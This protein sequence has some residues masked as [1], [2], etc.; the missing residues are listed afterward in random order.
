MQELPSSRRLPASLRPLAE[1]QH[2]VVTRA[3]L[4]ALHLGHEAVRSRTAQGIWRALGPRVVVLHTGTLSRQQKEWVGVLHSGPG[5][6]LAR[7]TA[8]TAAGLRGFEEPDV[9]VAVEHGREVSDLVHPLVTV[10]IHQT[11]RPA[12]ELALAREPVRHSIARAV[13]EMASAAATDNRCR[14]VLAAVVQQRLVRPDHLRDVIRTRPTMPRRRLV[15]ETIEDVAGGAHSL[16][17]LDYARALRRAGLPQPTRQRVVRRRGGVWYLD[18][19]FDEWA[20][21][22]EINGMQ[23]H[24]LLARE[25]DD[26]RRSSLQVRGRLVVDI[27]SY[28]VRHRERVAVLRTAE[29]LLGRGWPPGDRAR[30]VLAR[31]AAAEG[32]DSLTPAA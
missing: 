9:H 21:T 16:P 13:V 6:A 30:R 25:A 24:E 8:A 10:R 4:A 28:A 7:A 3:Q 31:Y 14:A 12:A 29:A 20:V 2:E 15:S 11:R 18:N 26:A 1:Q 32:W 5:S 23:H 27:S 17:E 22:I 19:D